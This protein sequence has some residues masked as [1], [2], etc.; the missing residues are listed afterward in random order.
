MSNVK[1]MLIVHQVLE[2]E[3]LGALKENVDGLECRTDS[4]SLILK[5]IQ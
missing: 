3:G 5:T 1:L 2:F 4:M